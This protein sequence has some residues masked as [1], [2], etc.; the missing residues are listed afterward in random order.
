MSDPSF[1][2]LPRLQEP[3]FVS[4]GG[5]LWP[6]CVCKKGKRADMK[7]VLVPLVQEMAELNQGPYVRLLCW[8]VDVPE[9]WSARKKCVTDSL[10]V[11]LAQTRV[12]VCARA[13]IGGLVH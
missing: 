2:P 5:I 1:A 3:V 11:S 10:C 6:W 4:D 8:R 12:H 9:N 7:G 13:F